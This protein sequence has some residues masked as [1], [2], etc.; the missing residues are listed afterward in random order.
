MFHNTERKFATNLKKYLQN[1][2]KKELE[3]W[4]SRESQGS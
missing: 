4:D 3:E 1:K 2:H